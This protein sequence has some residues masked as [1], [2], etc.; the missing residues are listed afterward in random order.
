MRNWKNWIKCARI[1]SLK[2]FAQTLVA[3]LPASATITAVDW[4]VTL[5]TAALAALASICTSLAGIPE[6]NIDNIDHI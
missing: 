3:L 1:R 6:E 2:T 5:G 4:K